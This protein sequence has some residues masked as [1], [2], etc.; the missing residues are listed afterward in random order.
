MYVNHEIKNCECVW[1]PNIHFCCTILLY[2]VYTTR[3]AKVFFKYVK[4]ILKF[5]LCFKWIRV[6]LFQSSRN[7]LSSLFSIAILGIFITK[8]RYATFFLP[9]TLSSIFLEGDGGG[10]NRNILIGL[11][12]NSEKNSAICTS[13]PSLPYQEKNPQNRPDK[14]K[15]INRV[16]TVIKNSLITIWKINKRP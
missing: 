8:S 15:D 16:R 10:S 6:T 12:P 14:M 4:L 7:F 5:K 2:Y 1:I 11:C 13:L 3:I 9:V